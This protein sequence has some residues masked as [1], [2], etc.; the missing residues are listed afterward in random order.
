VLFRGDAHT[1]STGVVCAADSNSTA[2]AHSQGVSCMCRSGMIV[3]WLRLAAC[4]C[5][6]VDASV[7]V[8]HTLQSAVPL[9]GVLELGAGV[10]VF[11]VLSLLTAYSQA[12][13]LFPGQHLHSDLTQCGVFPPHVPAAA[14]LATRGPT[15]P[16]GQAAGARVS[17][18]Q[19]A[20]T[21]PYTCQHRA[22]ACMLSGRA[23]PGSG[24]LLHR[25]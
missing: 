6:W 13:F 21:L 19:R 17:R 4:V 10:C 7:A 2:P 20:S 12:S 16:S 23:G 24:S 25:G 1:V 11:V 3:R 9:S 14:P 18:A 8:A 15:Q 22:A 5:V